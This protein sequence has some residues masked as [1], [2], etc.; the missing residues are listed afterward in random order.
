MEAY[1]VVVAYLKVVEA[2]Y[3]VVV[4]PYQ[5]LLEAFLKVVKMEIPFLVLEAYLDHPLDHLEQLN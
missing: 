2:S 4:D 5:V 1:Q 3:R